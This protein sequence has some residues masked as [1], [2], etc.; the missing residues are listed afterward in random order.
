MLQLPA[1][2]DDAI[3]AYTNRI[4]L[5]TQTANQIIKDFNWYGMAITFTGIE[6]TAYD[7][8]FNQI[9]PYIDKM[10]QHENEKLMQVLYHIDVSENKIGDATSEHEK[11][12][13]L[14]TRLIIMRELQKV[15]TRNY[16]SGR[17]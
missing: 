11:Q 4:D 5:I 8:L 14:L 1:F 9:E 2:N 15:V 17:L 13:A 16:F 6:S 10:L 12:S 7:E 3:Q